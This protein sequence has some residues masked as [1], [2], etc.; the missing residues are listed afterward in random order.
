V[1]STNSVCGSSARDSM[2]PQ[3]RVPIGF[4]EKAHS[5]LL[6][7]VIYDHF[8]LA[9]TPLFQRL[10]DSFLPRLPRERICWK[11]I[12]P[13]QRPSRLHGRRPLPLFLLRRTYVEQNRAM[14]CPAQPKSGKN[15][16]YTIVAGNGERCP[17]PRPGI[18]V[19]DS[20]SGTM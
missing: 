14:A 1:R 12:S 20:E 7:L 5:H 2:R 6:N 19:P 3:T 4:C 9:K 13:P 11:R 17:V 16:A 8:L 10:D 15:D 18:V